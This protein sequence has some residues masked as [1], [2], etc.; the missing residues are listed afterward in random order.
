MIRSPRLALHLSVIAG[1]LFVTVVGLVVMDHSALASLAVLAFLATALASYLA[2]PMRH[3]FA[4]AL[5]TLLFGYTMLGRGFAYL[6]VPPLHVGE[7]V[8][9]IGIVAMALLVPRTRSLRNPLVGLIM[10]FMVWGAVRTIPF[11]AQY[12]VDALRDA[13][14]WAYAAFALLVVIAIRSWDDLVNWGTWYA[15]AIPL[16][17]VWFPSYGVVYLLARD[18]F[19]TVPGTNV[20]LFGLKFGDMGVH[21]SGIAAFL[22]LGLAHQFA[23]DARVSRLFARFATPMWALWIVGFLIAS[24]NR[25]ALVSMLV[26][27]AVV[28]VFRPMNSSWLR[29]AAIA[30]LLSPAAFVVS[31]R[32]D[33]PPLAEGVLQRVESVMAIVT[34]REDEAFRASTVRWRLDWWSDIVGYTVFGDYRWAGKGY[35]VNLA[36]VD[37]YQVFSDESLR[38]PHNGHLTILARS[39]VTG[40]ALWLMLQGTFALSTIVKQHRLRRSGRTRAADVGVWI[41]AYWAAL[42]VNSSFDVFLEGPQGGI[43]IWTVVGVGVAWQILAQPKEPETPPTSA[44]PTAKHGVH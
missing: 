23:K 42:M 29:L 3:Y 36:N 44:V 2:R 5:L 12:G 1:G 18:A 4:L 15:R 34:G 41:I 8:L 30:L 14:V 16:W 27:L 11:I 20:P 26:S 35:G 37:G 25:G 39:G 13:V 24:S 7:L 31:L 38:S 43:W 40:V 22:A 10:L 33:A 32:P 17:L 19:P 28:V 6:G 9:A 21:L